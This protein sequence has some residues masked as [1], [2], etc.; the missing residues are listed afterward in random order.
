MASACA[1]ADPASHSYVGETRRKAVM[2]GPPARA[3]IYRI[4]GLHW[5][6][7]MVCADRGTTVYAR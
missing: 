2:F 1:S 7:N 4:Y 5:C 3:Y 6:L